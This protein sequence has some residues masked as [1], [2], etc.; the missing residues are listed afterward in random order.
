M[1]RFFEANGFRLEDGAAVN[2]TYG[3]GSAAGRAL[4]GG[5]TKRKKYEVRI[6]GIDDRVQVRVESAMSGW[7]G[8]LV[9]V[10]RERNQR[11]EFVSR[12]QTHLT[13]MGSG[14]SPEAAARR[15]PPPQR[16]APPQPTL[17][18]DRRFWWNGQLWIDASQAVPP[19]AVMS[20]DG[21]YWWD[22]VSWQSAPAA[23]GE[24]PLSGVS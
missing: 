7:S 15:L 21:L 2:G 18:P 14:S 8:S 17:S 19:G 23:K 3:S 13:A 11:K 10:A 4:A 9:G 22:G 12:L 24:T 20:P 6:T 16:T 1:A 5:F